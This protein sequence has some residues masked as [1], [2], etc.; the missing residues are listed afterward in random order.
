MV[1]NRQITAMDKENKW[2]TDSHTHVS[3]FDLKLI[4]V[5]LL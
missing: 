1:D 3:P 4:N 2:K 5:H